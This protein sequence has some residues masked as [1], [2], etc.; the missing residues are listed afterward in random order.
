MNENRF[1]DFE[2]VYQTYYGDIY[3]YLL[4]LS[5]SKETA[6]DVCQETFIK[7]YRYFNEFNGDSSIKTWMSKIAYRTYIDYLRKEKKQCFVSLTNEI[8]EK[9]NGYPIDPESSL[10]IDELKHILFESEF[11]SDYGKLIY[12]R[13]FKGLSYKE[14]SMDLGWDMTKVKVTLH[15]ARKSLKELYNSQQKAG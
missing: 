9:L 15:R 3:K 14:I 1:Q 7:V 4:Y 8:L 10:I 13:E 2:Q 12:L 11:K 5:N 6:E